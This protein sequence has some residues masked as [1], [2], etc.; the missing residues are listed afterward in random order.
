MWT[1]GKHTHSVASGRCPCLKFNTPRDLY[2]FSSLHPGF[3]TVAHTHTPII[4]F[5]ILASPTLL[6]AIFFFFFPREPQYGCWWPSLVS[7]VL[8]LPHSTCCIHFSSTSHCAFKQTRPLLTCVLFLLFSSV[9]LIQTLCL[10]SSSHS[11][12]YALFPVPSPL[13]LVCPPQPFFFICHS[14]LITPSL[15]FISIQSIRR[16]RW[17]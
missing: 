8:P 5:I 3:I 11:C 10:I 16:W 2:L 6:P 12:F 13:F 17:G 15:C 14:F 1:Q 7:L 4:I 9:T